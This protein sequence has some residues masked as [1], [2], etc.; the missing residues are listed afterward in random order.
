MR[1]A[2]GNIWSVFEQADLFLVTTNATL[3]RQGAL[4]MGAGIAR[5]ARD[6]FPGLDQKLG[7]AVAFIGSHY[8]VL[9]PT[10]WPE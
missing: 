3:N 2:Q 7:K 9:F 10:A 4:V 8:G 5:Q 6:R 1:L